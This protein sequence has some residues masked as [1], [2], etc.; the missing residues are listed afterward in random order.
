MSPSLIVGAIVMLWLKL[1]KDKHCVGGDWL[2]GWLAGW[3]DG[4][5][6]GWMAAWLAGPVACTSACVGS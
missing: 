3:L 2:A 1:Y 4:W 6:D 5:L